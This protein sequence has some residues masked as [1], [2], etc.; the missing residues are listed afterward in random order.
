[1]Y[2]FQ[3]SV[4]SPFR[5]LGLIVEHYQNTDAEFACVCEEDIDCILQV[6]PSYFTCKP[7]RSEI[8]G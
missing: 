2:L 5:R 4:Y 8:I 7:E 1:M 6:F 3:V